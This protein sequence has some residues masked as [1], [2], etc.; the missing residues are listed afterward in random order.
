MAKAVLI[1]GFPAADGQAYADHFA[2]EGGVI[3]F[4]GWGPFEE[5]TPPTW[6]R[7]P[8]TA[9]RPPL[10]LSQREASRFDE[11][12]LSHLGV[13]ENLSARPAS[14]AEEESKVRRLAGVRH[15]PADWI[16]R[17]RIIAL[18]WDGLH[19]P[20]IALRPVRPRPHRHAR[21]VTA[22]VG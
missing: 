2:I 10:F 18:S 11:P 9:S 12:P 7:R 6:T 5:R 20:A 13:C 8:G 19:V 14:D 15:A 16:P 3:P 4:P 1:D 17:A 21:P 22:P